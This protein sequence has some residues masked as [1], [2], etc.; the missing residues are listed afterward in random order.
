MSII[1]ALGIA[2]AVGLT[3]WVKSKLSNSDSNSAKIA[4]KVMD[5]AMSK[6]GESDPDKIQQRLSADPTLAAQ[7]KQTLLDN[8][9][10]ID[11][12]PYK[13]RQDA[14]A[15]HNKHPEQADKIADKIADRVMTQNLPYIFILLIVNV[16]A[17]YF[18]KDQGAIIATISNVLGM[19][20]KSLFDE[21]ICVTGFYFGSS[22]GS[23][24]KDE[25]ANDKGSRA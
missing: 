2:D 6:T 20:I 14:R 10:E 25:K 8:E 1:A 19:T 5:F 23:K 15:M 21:R 11:M 16:L 24:N 3:D 17:V 12:A 7:L 18:L 4:A 9:Q 13:D 22:M